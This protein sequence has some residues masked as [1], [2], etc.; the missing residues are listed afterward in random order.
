VL[1]KKRKIKKEVKMFDKG[2][3]KK[4]LPWVTIGLLVAFLGSCAPAAQSGTGA[5]P[6]AGTASGEEKKTYTIRVSSQVPSSYTCYQQVE[7]FKALVEERS[8][9]RL[10][11]EHYPLGQLYTDKDAM[12]VLSS[13]AVE[14]V[15][16]EDYWIT[17]VVP[18]FNFF[19]LPMLVRYEETM[20]KLLDS[21]EIGGELASMVEKK[22][23]CK[24]L[25]WTDVFVFDQA[26][27]GGKGEPVTSPDQLR[28][29]TIRAMNPLQAD[30]F[31]SWGATP[32]SITGG[33]LYT[34]FQRGT[35]QYG[36]NVTAHIYVR[37]LHEVT[38]FLTVLPS[39]M[40]CGWPV[41][42]NRDFYDS[43][44]ADLQQIVLDSAREADHGRRGEWKA[45]SDQWRA[46]TPET[47]N[48][49]ELSAEQLEVWRLACE[50][51]YTDC[52]TKYPVTREW[53]RLIEQCDAELD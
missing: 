22:A 27:I 41:L 38:D 18:E 7:D 10:K 35:L 45:I 48:Y 28:G 12:T 15:L 29:K 24:L 2:N 16:V 51:A 14:M 40:A 26:G 36:L 1:C 25:F 9:G 50:S 42:M 44:P 6:I 47:F 34:A 32:V 11:V 49:V 30:L 37:K 13:G 4:L 17:E 46:G 20:R 53:V 5:G 21:P 23:N 31:S 19:G 33:E 3:L 39:F 43:L 8:Q 52:Y